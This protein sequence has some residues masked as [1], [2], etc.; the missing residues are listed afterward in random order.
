MNKEKHLLNFANKKIFYSAFLGKFANCN[1]RSVQQVKSSLLGSVDVGE[2]AVHVKDLTVEE[3]L[4]I[5]IGTLKRNHKI[6]GE[7]YELS[8]LMYNPVLEKLSFLEAVLRIELNM[9]NTMLAYSS[10]VEKVTSQFLKYLKKMHLSEEETHFFSEFPEYFNNLSFGVE[11]KEPGNVH[12]MIYSDKIPVGVYH[13]GESYLGLVYDK[14]DSMYEL[15]TV[16]FHKVDYEA[17]EVK[18]VEALGLTKEMFGCFAMFNKHAVDKTDDKSSSIVGTTKTQTITVYRTDQPKSEALQVVL[19]VGLKTHLKHQDRTHMQYQGLAYNPL[20]KKVGSLKA[21]SQR[22]YKGMGEVKMDSKVE[23]LP[24]NPENLKKFIYNLEKLLVKEDMEFFTQ[25]VI[26]YFANLSL[27]DSVVSGEVTVLYPVR[28]DDIE[29]GNY[30][31]N[32]KTLNHNYRGL[33]VQDTKVKSPRYVN[34]IYE[35]AGKPQIKQK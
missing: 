23:Y 6:F 2:I 8:G 25:H 18:Y 1:R 11:E 14:D 5:E 16:K 21:F 24:D 15:K 9:D 10:P 27:G 30:L 19:G 35:F 22:H 34:T 7:T 17:T 4:K 3:D 31:V 13:I 33:M 26:P 12:R 32:T 29:I 20:I 28:S